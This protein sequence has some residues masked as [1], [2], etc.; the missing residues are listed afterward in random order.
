[1]N[2][3]LETPDEIRRRIWQELGR[4]S[5]DRHHAW[6]TPVLATAADDGGVDAR[7]V[8]LR[9]AD[10]AL[11]T[12]AFYTD[13]RSRK[14]ADIAQRPD[15][16]LV[17]WCNRLHWQLRVR[18]RV[19]AQTSGPEVDAL[20]QRVRQSPSAGDY[21][22]PVAPGTP[23]AD[24]HGMPQPA[25]N[26]SHFTVLTAKVTEIDWLELGRSGHRRARM[27][28]DASLP[29]AWEWLTP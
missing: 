22:S 25:S 14:V 10:A 2:T 13:Q 21:L 24:A 5:L 8:V 3:P 26:L 18:A 16:M 28:T 15:A 17:F 23:R 20:W 7:T 19:S 4:A 1:M 6:R 11:T 29:G 27:L 9:S 12:L